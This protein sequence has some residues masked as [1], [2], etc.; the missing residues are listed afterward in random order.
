MT[1]AID[2][3][4]T[5]T[6]IAVFKQDELLHAGQYQQVDTRIINNFMND[7]PVK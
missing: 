6:K 1:L 7:Y 4:N 5:Y 3:G 2:I